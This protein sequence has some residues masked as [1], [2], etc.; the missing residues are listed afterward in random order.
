MPEETHL[1][2]TFWRRG[3]SKYMELSQNEKQ[4][5]RQDLAADAEAILNKIDALKS[6]LGE[7]DWHFA[8]YLD[9]IKQDLEKFRSNLK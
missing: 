1:S 5:I 4:E 8:Q 7:R 9:F 6:R 3:I 2:I